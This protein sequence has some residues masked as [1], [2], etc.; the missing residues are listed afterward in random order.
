MKGLKRQSLIDLI[1]VACGGIDNVAETA[2]LN[3][4]SI[5]DEVE[6]IE[7]SF[8]SVLKPSVV[9]WFN[10]NQLIPATG[11]SFEEL[12]E[13]IGEGGIDYMGIEIDFIVS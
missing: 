3:N 7:L 8:P 13:T 9:N 6:N 2:K 12:Q 4:I 10:V 11:L 5:T 1:I